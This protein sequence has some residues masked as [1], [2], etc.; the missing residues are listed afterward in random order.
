M[1]NC[2]CNDITTTPCTTSTGCTSTNYSKCIVYS[3]TSLTDCVTVTYGDNLDT[4]ISSIVTAICDLTPSDLSWGTFD[5]GCLSA[6]TSAQEFAEGISAAHCALDARVVLVEKPTFTLCPLFTSGTYTITPGTT[7][8][9]T[10]L[11]YFA[12]IL[13]DLTDNNPATITVPNYCFTSNTGITTLETY[14]TWIVENVCSIRTAILA[15]TTSN[16]LAT[17]AIQTYLGTPSTL[18]SKHDMTC[19]GGGAT[20]T[21]YASIELVRDEVCSLSTTVAAMPDLANVTLSWGA[22]YAYGAT[23]T[24]STQLGRLV[25]IVKQ[26]STF[27]DH[28]AFSSDFS[29]SWGACGP[30]VSLAGSVGAFSCSDLAA[31]SV[32]SLGDVTPTI[33]TISE[34]GYRLTW[35]HTNSYYKLVAN[36]SFTNVGIQAKAGLYSAESNGFYFKNQVTPL[37]CSQQLDYQIG[38]VE[39]AWL[40]M[41][42]YIDA[43]YTQAVAIY[44]PYIKK[45]WDG[46]IYLKGAISS[47]G[48]PAVGAPEQPMS[49]GSYST[50]FTGIPAAYRPTNTEFVDIIIE[51]PH[52]SNGALNAFV[53]GKLQITSTGNIL[54]RCY[55]VSIAAD[56]GVNYDGDH[57]MN[58]TGIA[59]YQ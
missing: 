51:Y 8:L 11:G 48:T 14:L 27:I 30:V 13:C 1:S 56:I 6:F 3:G 19:V 25:T 45:T 24:L 21:A 37:D 55:D 40:D 15:I 5:Y 43:D 9:Q 47:V 39:D 49:N 32:H 35:D 33:P 34:C 17:T 58:F 20:E 52:N 59:I 28:T 53:P 16:T 46:H 41:T 26:L 23:D 7:T 44:K 38:F 18:A 54:V 2:G 42:A 50:L 10:I 36:S 29:V 12:D 31:C 57:N 22:C 4:V